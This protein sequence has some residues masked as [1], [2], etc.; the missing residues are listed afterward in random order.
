ML[1]ELNRVAR[2]YLI[3]VE[4]DFMNAPRIQ[5]KRMK[6]LGYIG[7]LLQPLS[8]L[9]L[10]P[11]EVRPILNNSNVNNRASIFVI[12]MDRRNLDLAPQDPATW[13]DPIMGEELTP[14]GSGLGTS[15]GLW[16]PTLMGIPFLRSSDAK[17]VNSN[18]IF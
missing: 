10:A 6:T 15:K 9:G 11:I 18:Q 8:L 16:F 7:A 13:I 14:F 12:P 5:Q 3:L 2:K 1:T 17:I 4:P